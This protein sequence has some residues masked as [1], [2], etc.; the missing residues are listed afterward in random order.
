MFAVTRAAGHGDRSLVASAGCQ[1]IPWDGTAGTVVQ[2][3][4]GI[5]VSCDP[6]FHCPEKGMQPRW[7]FSPAVF[8]GHCRVVDGSPPGKG[9]GERVGFVLNVWCSGIR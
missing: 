6:S 5:P 3:G 8:P 9:T 2:G 1:L 7:D 4:F